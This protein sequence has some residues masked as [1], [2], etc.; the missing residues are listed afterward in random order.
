M[1]C[2]GQRHGSHLIAKPIQ[3][4][5]LRADKDQA[6]ILYRFCEGAFFAQQA[7]ARMDG[8]CAAGPGCCDHGGNIQIGVK[9]LAGQGDQL[10]H[11]AGVQ[12]I[13]IILR[14]HPDRNEALRSC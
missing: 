11:R 14:G 4:V 5:R 6:C 13:V 12:G 8:I 10:I 1:L 9:A 3:C 7:I 2:A